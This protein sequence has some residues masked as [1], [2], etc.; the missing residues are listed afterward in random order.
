LDPLIKTSPFGEA[1]MYNF[2]F[3]HLFG[4]ICSSHILKRKEEK[5]SPPLS[6]VSQRDWVKN[7]YLKERGN[8]QM[9]RRDR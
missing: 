3:K 8:K 4:L 6:S 7:R 5:K 1:F 2:F 9:V